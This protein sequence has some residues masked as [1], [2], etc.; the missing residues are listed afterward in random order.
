MTDLALW[1]TEHVEPTATGLIIT[2]DLTLDEWAGIGRR[3]GTVET[4]IR[5]A[6]GDWMLYGEERWPTR[7]ADVA[8][9]VGLSP[10][11]IA[12]SVSVARRVPP[13]MRRAELTWSHHDEVA[14][15]H[16]HPKAQ[17]DLLR[18]AVENGLSSRELRAEAQQ[19]KDTLDY[20]ASLLPP[21]GEP[22]LS[23]A[24]NITCDPNA[25]HAERPAPERVKPDVVMPAPPALA[26]V[27]PSID[28]VDDG[29][30]ERQGTRHWQVTVTAFEDDIDDI[31]GSLW[32]WAR[33]VGEK[34]HGA[35]VEVKR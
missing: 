9:E 35:I 22:D 14:A 10:Q 31:A 21:E 1:G 24:G 11:S 34:W 2:G 7:Y 33:V 27:R 20:L 25:S 32:A 18:K 16:K 5:W 29:D 19:A 15:L 28:A 23:G 12:T 13:E 3:M 6:I 17:V 4:H 8:A 30:L 26:P